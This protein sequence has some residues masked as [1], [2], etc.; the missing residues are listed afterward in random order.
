MAC[1]YFC[2]LAN[3]LR[4]PMWASRCLRDRPGTMTATIRVSAV[5]PRQS[6]PLRSGS[7]FFRLYAGVGSA[8]GRGSNALLGVARRL[9]EKWNLWRQLGMIDERV[10]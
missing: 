8:D 7:L 2:R 10:K 5:K 3:H 4:L 6:V 9:V 1:A